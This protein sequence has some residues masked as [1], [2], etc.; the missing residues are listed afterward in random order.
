MVNKTNFVVRM[1]GLRENS[2]YIDYLG[3]YKIDEIAE[4]VGIKASVIKEKY[5]LNQ[6]EHEESIDVYYFKSM[7]NAQN[8]ISEILKGVK[9]EKKGRT[10]V[11]TEAEVEYIRRALINEGSNTIHLRNKVKDAIFKKLN[12]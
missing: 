3:A 10:I 11:L 9:E 8:A 4:L 6:A 5:L 12:D 1:S 7:E 2:Y